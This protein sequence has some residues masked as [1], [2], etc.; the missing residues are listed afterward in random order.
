MTLAEPV[1]AQPR[2]VADGMLREPKVCPPGTTVA[3]ARRMFR[4]EH[5]HALL[6]VDRGV[7]R[8]VVE[9]ADLATADPRAAAAGLGA[10]AGRVVRPGADLG[11]V[12]REMRRA[13]IRRLA[14][15]DDRGRLLGLLCLKRSGR[16][17]CSADDVRA[18][19]AAGVAGRP[20]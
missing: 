2:W 16:G 4:D 10:L 7:L 15:V 3:A 14:V 13:G 5:V 8:A 11:A 9:R 18:R 19:S 20:R 1:A 17:F 6:V 12:H